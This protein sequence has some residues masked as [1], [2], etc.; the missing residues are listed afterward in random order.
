[1]KRIPIVLL[2]SVACCVPQAVGQ[3]PAAAPPQSLAGVVRLNKVPVSNEVLKV[4]L[5]RPVEKQ[6]SNGIKLLVV[7]SHR[8]PNI[9][10]T[11]RI[12]TGDLRN[13]PDLP[14]LADATAALIRL[15]TKT[16]N[17][18]QIAEKLAELGASL[19]FGS[20]EDSGTIGISAMTE[21]FDAALALL[22]DVL[23]NPTF[24]QDEFDKWKN[25]QKAQLEQMKSQPGFLATEEMYKILYPDDARKS[26]RVTAASLDKMTRD[27]RGGPITGSTMYLRVSGPVS[28]VTSRLP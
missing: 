11:I 28:R 14:G 25:R 5:P 8:V 17:S 12:P 7:E 27:D 1:M 10:L 16:S 24:P 6:L 21:N 18:Q 9:V 26:I 3:A 19:N 4:K 15:G 2:F 23:L 22:T 13:P 20:G